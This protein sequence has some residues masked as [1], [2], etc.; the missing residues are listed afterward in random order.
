MIKYNYNL[1]DNKIKY[2]KVHEQL[3]NKVNKEGHF[4]SVLNAHQSHVI[5]IIIRYCKF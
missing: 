1:C 2:N 3:L 5:T 4:K